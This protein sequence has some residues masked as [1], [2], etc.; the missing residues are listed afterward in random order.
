MG[1]PSFKGASSGPAVCPALQAQRAAASR[2]AVNA[3]GRHLASST[4]LRGRFA[5]RLCVLGYRTTEADVE[6]LVRAVV[7]AAAAER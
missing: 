1:L 5:L 7:E 6:G 3:T 2:A 4:R